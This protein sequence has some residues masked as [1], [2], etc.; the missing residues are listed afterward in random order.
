MKLTSA[1]KS[2]YRHHLANLNKGGVKN[3]DGST[4]TV[5]AKTVGFG[6]K[7]YVLPTVWDNKIVDLDTA[8]KNA[9][10]KGLDSFPSY[11]SPEEAKAR[12]MQMHDF[13]EG[14]IR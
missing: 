3:A 5:L 4:S 12:Y 1:E 14:D 6:D 8:I 7:T 10:A 13:M 9:R 11:G 2:L